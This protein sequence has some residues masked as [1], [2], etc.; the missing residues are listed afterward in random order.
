MPTKT[1]KTLISSRIIALKQQVEAGNVAALDAFWRGV[2]AEG[3]PL[4]EPIEGDDQHALVTFLWC[5]DE[6]VE[7]V[8]LYSEL[9]RGSWWNNW[10]D[11]ILTHLPGTNLYY[12]TYQVRKDM[13]FVY[14]LSPNHPLCDPFARNQH[15]FQC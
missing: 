1:K 12:R 11:A 10:T 5:A 7:H 6:D 13:R 14:W 9:L 2:T 8:V 4:I 3:T 15:I